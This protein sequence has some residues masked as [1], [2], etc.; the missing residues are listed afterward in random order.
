MGAVVKIKSK[1]KPVQDAHMN[2]V[3]GVALLMNYKCFSK[4]FLLSITGLSH[5]LWY[6]LFFSKKT[7]QYI[8][9]ASFSKF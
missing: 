3:Q 9:F 4:H 7:F 2:D 6:Q 5:I 1:P 8:G